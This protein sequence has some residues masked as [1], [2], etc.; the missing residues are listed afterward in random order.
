M[1]H[2][3]WST[4]RAVLTIITALIEYDAYYRLHVN[5]WASQF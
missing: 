4:I 1:Y 5:W 3:I 2:K